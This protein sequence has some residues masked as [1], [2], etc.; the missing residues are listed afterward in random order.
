MDTGFSGAV[1]LGSGDAGTGNRSLGDE[2]GEVSR[3]L[4]SPQVET[5]IAENLKVVPEGS[6]GVQQGIIV[7]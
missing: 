5:W 6:T 3:C 4:F 2:S 1:F 7:S